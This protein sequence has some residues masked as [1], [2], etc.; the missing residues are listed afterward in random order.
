ML[1]KDRMTKHTA[2]HFGGR[3][4]RGDPP[5]HARAECTPPAVV[6]KAGGHVGAGCESDL[7]KA[8]VD[9]NLSEHV[10]ESTICST[11]SRLRTS[12]YAR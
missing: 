3:I 8:T 12:W 11:A 10:G 1:I 2:D 4:D 9:R 5:L 6:N 7:L